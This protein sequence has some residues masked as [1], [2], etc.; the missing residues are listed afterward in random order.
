MPGARRDERGHGRRGAPPG[1][2][3]NIFA[4]HSQVEQIIA[5][6][7][8]QGVSLTGSERAGSAVA[9]IAGGHLKKCVL[10]LG[11]SDPYVVLDAD[12]IAAAGGQAGGPASTTPARRATPTSG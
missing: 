4:S 9:A 10:E 3:Q 7:R 1:R 8:V 2:Y 5:D 12:D 6:R 11:G